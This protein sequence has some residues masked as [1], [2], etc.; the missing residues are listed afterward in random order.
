[1]PLLGI[2]VVLFARTILSNHILNSAIVRHEIGSINTVLWTALAMRHMRTP[3]PKI[4]E[5]EIE[6]SEPSTS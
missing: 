3:L 1:V 2:F 6:E 4:G 5:R